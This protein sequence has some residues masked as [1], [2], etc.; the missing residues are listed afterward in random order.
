MESTSAQ[1]VRTDRPPANRT[2]VRSIVPESGARKAGP[3]RIGFLKGEVSVPDDFD[4]MGQEHGN[5]F[6]ESLR[7]VLM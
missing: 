1:R 6:T 2:N 7:Y 4:T 5:Q 3:Q